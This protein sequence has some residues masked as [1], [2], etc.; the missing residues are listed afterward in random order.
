MA[1]NR[2]REGFQERTN[3]IQRENLSETRYEGMGPRASASRRGT[4]SMAF[5]LGCLAGFMMAIG[6]CACDKKPEA[7][8]ESESTS[9]PAATATAKATAR[10]AVSQGKFV[11]AEPTMSPADEKLAKHIVGAISRGARAAYA[12]EP[13][14]DAVLCRSA[15]PVPTVVPKA[16]TYEPHEKDFLRGS[17]RDTGWKCL[18]F[19]LT[20][21]FRCQ[22]GYIAGGPYKSA[23]RG[24]KDA[25]KEDK[26]GA[27]TGFEAYA[28][29]DFDGD[30]ETS[31]YARTGTIVNG[32][33]TFAKNY[34]FIDK[35]GE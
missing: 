6:V 17:D 19:E 13:F 23:E 5:R 14:P 10:K 33:I 26:T 30:G 1:N 15:V 34:L 2:R 7:E 27:P 12:R 29:C 31:L 18:K 16:Q 21:P 3:S 9:E 4:G 35:K 22:Y 32:K 28:E 24:N 8:S 25:P 20:N 11:P